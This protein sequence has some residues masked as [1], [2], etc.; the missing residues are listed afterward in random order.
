MAELKIIDVGN[1]NVET[2]GFYCAKNKKEEGFRKK[3]EWLRLR[4]AEGLKIKLLQD[5]AGNDAG[6]VEY[7]P[8]EF[9]WRPV[10]AGGYL[11]I[12]CIMVAKKADR[13][14]GNGSRL[15]QSVL[16]EAEQGGWNGVAVACSD[17]PW[18]ATRQ[19]FEKNGFEV[20]DRLGRFELLLKKFRAEAAPPKFINWEENCRQ[21]MGWHLIF[22]HQCPWHAKA[23]R[24]LRQV[25]MEADLDLHISEIKNAREAQHSP[26][27]F[28]VFGLIHDGRLLADHYISATRF[29]NILKKEPA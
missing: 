8:G 16:A 27:G 1:E 24:D 20:T 22:S 10:D 6:F 29:R 17:G 11:F 5:E 23:V 19:L 9:A 25:A 2:F 14:S 13:E 7:V 18:L 4:F 28:G 26:S 3:L 21:L 12:H 15:V